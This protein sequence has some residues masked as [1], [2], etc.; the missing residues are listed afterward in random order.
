MVNV[1]LVKEHIYGEQN[2]SCSS[3][4]SS[5]FHECSKNLFSVVY[6]NYTTV[7]CSV[8]SLLLL[9]REFLVLSKFLLCKQAMV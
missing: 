6:S 8:R 7:Q 3:P 2:V 1:N 9:G 4:L 5:V